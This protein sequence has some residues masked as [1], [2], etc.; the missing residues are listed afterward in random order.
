[1]IKAILFDLDGVIIDS[2]DNHVS[3]YTRVLSKMNIKVTPEFIKENFGQGAPWIFKKVFEMHNLDLNP[4]AYAKLKDKL[5]REDFAKQIKT[6]PGITEFIKRP[7]NS[8]ELL[9]RVK[10]LIKLRIS[11]I[12]LEQEQIIIKEDLDHKIKIGREHEKSSI[13]LLGSL[14]SILTQI[15]I[16]I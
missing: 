2:I 1:M 6:Y 8:I 11:Q 13:I 12:I 15:L 4:V 10:N 16:N 5:F 7:F 9:A 3:A 14:L